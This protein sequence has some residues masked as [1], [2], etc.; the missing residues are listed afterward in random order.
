MDRT[1]PTVRLVILAL[2]ATTLSTLA[3][4][5]AIILDARK[6]LFLD[7]YLIA[8]LTRVKRT[9]ESA[10]KFQGNPL[11]WPAEKWEEPR[12]LLYG[13]IIRDGGKFRM[14]YL[15][16]HSVASAESELGRAH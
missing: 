7:N 2:L 11:L 13:S 9:V 6:Q 5:S 10:R 14:W 16:G 8:S 1:H 15:S 12:A 4:D 3:A